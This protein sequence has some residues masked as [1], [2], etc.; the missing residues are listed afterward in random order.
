MKL[1]VALKIYFTMWNLFYGLL[2]DHLNLTWSLCH[3]DEQIIIEILDVIYLH[4][5]T[6]QRIS[7]ILY[8]LLSIYVDVL[9]YEL[10]DES[11]T[12]LQC[13]CVLQFSKRIGVA[14]LC[15]KVDTFLIW[16]FNLM[17]I[18]NHRPFEMLFIFIPKKPLNFID[19]ENE[20]PRNFN[21]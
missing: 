7:Y 17:L 3:I 9:G 15:I 5:Q 21:K 2:Q 13:L 6:K 19:H 12:L 11:F 14:I 16:S 18:S 10:P 20:I 1:T 4:L 8:Q